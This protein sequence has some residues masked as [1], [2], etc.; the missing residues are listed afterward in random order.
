MKAIE[1]TDRRLERKF[2]DM[3]QIIYHTDK[4]YA[5]PLDQDIR[6]VFSPAENNFFKH[7][8]A[9]RWILTDDAGLVI[10]RIAA[11]ID[12]KQMNDTEQPTGGI[13]FFECI[14]DQKAAVFLFDTAKEWLR[15]RGAMA[16]NGPINF[17]ETDK[18]W[19]LLVEGFTQ[20]AYR[21]AY[22]PPYYRALFENYGFK[23]FYK[24]EGFHLDLN[25]EI[26]ERFW[27]IAEWIAK[28]P[29]YS[30]EHLR[31]E[32]LDRFVRDFT[33]VYNEAWS[34]FKKNF[35][36]LQEDYVRNFIKKGRRVMEE[37][38]IWFAYHKGEPI[39]IY[40]M[41]PDLN[42]LF[43]PF[44]GKLGLWN[45]LRLLYILKQGKLTRARGVLMGVVPRFQGRGIE[46]AFIWHL[47]MVLSEM[48]RYTE[49]EFSWVGDFNPPMRKLW[50]AVGAVP[51]KHYITYRY[52]FDPNATFKRYPIPGEK[53]EKKK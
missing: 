15:Q 13:G 5:R 32:E 30:F 28:K 44:N 19:G 36:P 21:I 46:S 53:E 17:G 2:L 47:D 14:N 3:V 20:P 29:D 25:K 6:G 48:S 26:P 11:F 23:I 35:E 43:K 37:K 39:A 49:L 18:F 42:Q 33:K 22:N 7:G 4:N 31:F 40:L 38:F 52:L 34:D 12:R 41:Y 50:L 27:R 9:A 51:A 45:K 24:Q 16:M 1:V 8:V 10:G